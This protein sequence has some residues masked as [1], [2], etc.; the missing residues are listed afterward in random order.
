[1]S[2]EAKESKRPES[3]RSFKMPK[4]SLAYHNEIL[5]TWMS[6]INEHFQNINKNDFSIM[7]K[8]D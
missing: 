4:P 8:Q 6:K 3:S 7:Q 1:M 2:V 5:K